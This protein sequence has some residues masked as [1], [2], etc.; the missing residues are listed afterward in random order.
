MRKKYNFLL[1]LIS[2][3]SILNI[4]CSNQ[5]TIKIAF[6]GN[7]S[8]RSSDIGVQSRNAAVMLVDEVNENGGINGRKIELI[9]KDDKAHPDTALAVDKAAYNEGARIFVG[10]MISAVIEKVYKF[11]NSHDVI[12][13]SP[14]ISTNSLTGIEDNFFRV[15]SSNSFQ[16]KLIAETAFNNGKKNVVSF[17]EENNK[18]YTHELLLSFESR[19][20]EL[21]GKILYSGSFK[22]SNYFNYDSLIHKV[23]TFKPDAIVSIA[24]GVDNALICQS[25]NKANSDLNVFAGMWTMTDDLFI[26]GGKSIS[27]MIISG[28]HDSND[29]SKA[30]LKFFEKYKNRY[31]ISPTFPS[32]YTYEALMVLFESMKISNSDSPEEIKRTII[33]KGIFQGLQDTFKIDRFGDAHR[34]YFPFK[35]QNKRYIRI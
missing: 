35:V 25:L 3:L 32:I 10:H 11:A 4:N 6:C 34:E 18:N 14:T 28:I 16:G 31:K 26:H 17:F 20:K 9:I 22:S 7:L 1:L 2:V 5:R 27:R 19:F 8:G 24:S 23:L 29:S 33:D 30:F 21:G 15:M 12:F 13:M